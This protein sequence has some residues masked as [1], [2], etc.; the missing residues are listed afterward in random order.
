MNTSIPD[1]T[2]D[3][4]KATL[5]L[6]LRRRR[7][8]L[9][10][11]LEGLGEYDIRRPLVPSGTNLLGLVKHVA[12]VQLDYFGEVFGRPSGRLLPWLA[13]DAE[14]EADMWATP[15]ESRDAILDLHA[16]SAAH[17]DSTIGA[18]PLDAPGAVPWWPEE[19]RSVTL[20]QILVHMVSETAQHAGHA[21]ILRELIDG[22]I[23][24]GPG[25]PNLGALTAEGR[26]AHARRVDAAARAASG[27]E[28]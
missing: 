14:P 8:D 6:Y 18:L 26:T 10:G 16:F 21:D 15:E 27:G 4:H 9:V 22:S 5:L 17:S 7:E 23:G 24:R 28:G 1:D 19:R 20:H 25:D 11:K 13:D 2:E 3:L 12:S